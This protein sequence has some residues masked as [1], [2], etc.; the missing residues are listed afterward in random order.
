MKV[1][2]KRGVSTFSQTIRSTTSNNEEAAEGDDGDDD[3][4]DAFDDETSDDD[5]LDFDDDDDDLDEGEGTSSSLLLELERCSSHLKRQRKDEKLVVSLR[6]ADGATGRLKGKRVRSQAREGGCFG[7]RY[8]LECAPKRGDVLL[9]EVVSTQSQQGGFTN[10][11]LQLRGGGEKKD[12]GTVVATGFR[13]IPFSKEGEEE[14]SS[15][16][17]RMHSRLKRKQAGGEVVVRMLSKDERPQ[18]RKRIFLFRHG[19]SFWNKAQRNRDLK[20]MIKYDHPL[21]EAGARQCEETRRRAKEMRTTAKTGEVGKSWEDYFAGCEVAL[22]SPLTR[23]VQTAILILDEHPRLTT[24]T[25]EKWNNQG[26][27]GVRNKLIDS[28]EKI[29]IVQKRNKNN[30]KGMHFRYS[31]SCREIKSVGGFDSVGIAIGADLISQRALDKFALVDE[32]RAREVFQRFRRN[33]A[34]IVDDR[35]VRDKWWTGTDDSDSKR[36]VAKR[37]KEF[38][39]EL[40]SLSNDTVIV[41][42]HSD[43]IRKLLRRTRGDLDELKQAKEAKICNAGCI[44]L[45][46]EWSSGGDIIVHD[47]ELL[48][49]TTFIK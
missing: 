36:T 33:S 21:T 32:T 6:V 42:S 34:L 11:V 24:M 7:H 28:E 37:T 47:C 22:V 44:G 39:R 5:Y 35:D 48:F 25:S 13:A 23:A 40:K 8:D 16:T 2:F 15:L 27:S 31:R 18:R 46:V 9:C 4:D 45:D 17:I 19:E 12:N 20:S 49:G 29:D 14:P 26:N 3:V 38:W 10:S 41:V 1:A 30:K 43:F